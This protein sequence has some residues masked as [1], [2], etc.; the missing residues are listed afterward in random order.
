MRG[1]GGI[2]D[3]RFEFC[4]GGAEFSVVN[5]VERNGWATGVAIYGG[6]LVVIAVGDVWFGS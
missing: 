4:E 1:G 5:L 2:R 3:V 6:I